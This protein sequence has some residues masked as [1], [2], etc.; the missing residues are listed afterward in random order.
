MAIAQTAPAE[1]ALT[2]PRETGSAFE[3]L[4]R[5]GA[6][7]IDKVIDALTLTTKDKKTI[8]LSGID[9][10][11]YGTND[12]DL[13]LLAFQVLEKLLPEGKEV[14]LYQTRNAKSGRENRMGQMLA[15]LHDEKDNVWIQGALISVGL[16]RAMP[17]D[18][19]PEMTREMLIL[20]QQARTDKKGIWA[21]DSAYRLFT[22]DEL[23]GKTGTI[24]VVE[25]TVVKTANV[26]NTLYLNFG[27]DWKTDFTVRLDTRLR[28]E[29]SRTGIDP[30]NLTGKTV[31][32]RGYIEDYNGPMI[33]L[34]TIHHLEILPEKAPQ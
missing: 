28:K 29:L 8:R 18:T 31:R 26:R 5:T 15:H 2:Q 34:E 11:G 6:S 23:N 13:S 25:G 22:P 14:A 9:V 12:S 33:T 19:N 4:K 10:P 24:Q 27:K 17:N 32:V 7:R 20:E 16:A 1:N 3:G 30:M 21:D